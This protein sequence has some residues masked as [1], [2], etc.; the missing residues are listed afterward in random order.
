MLNT[1]LEQ[2]RRS[3]ASA[4]VEKLKGF[5]ELSLEQMDRA[6]ASIDD[7]TKDLLRMHA[8]VILELVKRLTEVKQ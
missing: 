4:T 7:N 1:F 8:Y 6:P 5:A 2:A 3:M